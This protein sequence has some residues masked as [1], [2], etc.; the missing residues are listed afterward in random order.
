[1]GIS[2]ARFYDDLR[3]P[4]APVDSPVAV[5]AAVPQQAPPGDFPPPDINAPV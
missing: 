4:N 1:M 5:Q 2:M 3:P